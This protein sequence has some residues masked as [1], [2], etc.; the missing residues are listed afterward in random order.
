ML[1]IKGWVHL[2]SRGSW[3]MMQKQIGMLFAFF[4]GL[5]IFQ[6]RWLTKSAPAFSIG[7]VS[8]QTY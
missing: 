5:E 4:M 1:K 7:L 6:S 8:R 2:F 3:Q